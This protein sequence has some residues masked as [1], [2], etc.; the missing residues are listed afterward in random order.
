MSTRRRATLVLL[1]ASAAAASGCNSQSSR[2]AAY[3]ANPTPELD[4]TSQ[5]RHDMDNRMTVT[6]DTN[7]RMFNEDLGR[8][9]FL[10]R[11]SRL[12]PK[13]VPY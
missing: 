2:L 6:N 11:P 7:L 13:P 9:F 10:D 5:R 12:S 8:M 1:A 4:T 3:R